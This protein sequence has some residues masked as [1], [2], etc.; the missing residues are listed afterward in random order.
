MLN[1][2]FKVFVKLEG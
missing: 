1:V 2:N